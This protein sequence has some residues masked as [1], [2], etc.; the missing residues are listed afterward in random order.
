MR[1]VCLGN[2]AQDA[3]DSADRRYA[4]TS[5]TSGKMLDYFNSQGGNTPLKSTTVVAKN[6]PG[7]FDKAWGIF[8]K[9]GTIATPTKA[10]VVIQTAKPSPPLAAIAGV[11]V[12]ALL[13][14]KAVK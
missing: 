6:E 7:W 14:F 8:E 10:P 11:G 12:V 13:L 1:I 5:S 3:I 2:A 9:L 4:L